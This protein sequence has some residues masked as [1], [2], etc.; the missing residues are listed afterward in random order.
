MTDQEIAYRFVRN[1]Q[2]INPNKSPLILLNPCYFLTSMECFIWSDTPE[3]AV[4]W[5]KFFLRMDCNEDKVRKF[6]KINYFAINKKNFVNLRF[7]L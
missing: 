6:L 2:K 3:G 7:M 1:F 4:F 5:H